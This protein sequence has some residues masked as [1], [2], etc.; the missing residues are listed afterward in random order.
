[1]PFCRQIRVTSP[2]QPE[3]IAMRIITLFLFVLGLWAV[4]A[5]AQ[6]TGQNLISA[7][8]EAQRYDLLRAAHSQRNAT[9]NLWRATRR[10]QVLI[11]AGTFHLDDPRHDA[12]MLALLPLLAA[13]KTLLV[14]AGPAEE[15]ALRQKMTTDTTVMMSVEGP[16]LADNLPPEEWQKLTDA[17]LQRGIPSSLSTKLQ[18]WFVT[19]ML[20]TPPCALQLA[21]QGRGLDKRL[22][23]VAIAQGIPIHALEPFDTALT[24]FDRLSLDEQITMIRNALLIEAQAADYLKT[25][26]DAFFAGD[27]R[28]AW[29]FNRQ[30]SYALPGVT[31]DEIDGQFIQME[32]ALLASRNRNWIA[33]IEQTLESGPTFA[34]F[35]ALHLSGKEGVLALLEARGFLLQRL[36]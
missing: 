24:L 35:G 36:D 27:S 14:E 25:T 23:D 17:L 3:E 15:D 32:E 30:I 9:G 21:A 5:H 6:C 16:R 18:P 2:L 31:R 1:M 33:T 4:P 20:S 34:A 10:D 28:L 13:S 22:T 11:V 12:L 26:A 8:P 19:M 7:L 29:E